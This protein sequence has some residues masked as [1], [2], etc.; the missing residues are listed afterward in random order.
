M[1]KP[2]VKH[3]QDIPQIVAGDQCLLQQLFHPNS[4]PVKTHY[5]LA[6]AY[7]EP[8]GRTLN[9]KLEQSETYYIIAG[10]GT[11]YLDGEP[12]SVKTGSSYYIPPQ[13]EQWLQ[14]EGETR[15]EFLV[16]VDPPWTADE[17]T[18]LESDDD[19]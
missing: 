17:E 11:M 15:L 14:N 4:D 18:I 5:S 16:I 3:L 6:Y 12:H 19:S 13:C 1:N 2:V 8:G 7:L 10:T 9:H